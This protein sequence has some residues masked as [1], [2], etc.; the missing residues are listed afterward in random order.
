M[1]RMSLDPV[2][3]IETMCAC[4]LVTGLP[5]NGP[6]HQLGNFSSVRRAE[7]HVPDFHGGAT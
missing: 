7:R 1:A 6:G 5:T 4:V 2:A 3:R